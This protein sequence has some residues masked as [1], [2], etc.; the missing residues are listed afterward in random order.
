VKLSNY[1]LL[2]SLNTR[3]SIASQSEAYECES[4]NM[5]DEEGARK[6]IR[7]KKR[8]E[9]KEHTTS[10]LSTFYQYLQFGIYPN[11]RS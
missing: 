2:D 1:Q 10:I 7:K 11:Y 4:Y 5:E 9:K 8:T 6:I 3:I